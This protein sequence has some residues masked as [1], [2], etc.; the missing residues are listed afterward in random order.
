[1][2]PCNRQAGTSGHS[3]HAFA[4]FPQVNELEREAE[5]LDQLNGVLQQQLSGLVEQV[6]DWM[7]HKCILLATGWYQET[8]TG[9][10]PVTLSW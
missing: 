10:H 4:P 1:V 6:C 3:R 2:L 5:R 7:Q 8:C 9:C